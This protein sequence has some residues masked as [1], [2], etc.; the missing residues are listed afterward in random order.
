M[1]QK[2]YA[3]LK[4]EW[5][6]RLQGRGLF[7]ALCGCLIESRKDLS[8][9]HIICRSKGGPTE[10]WN[11]QPTHKWCN[12]AR[13]DMPMQKWKRQGYSTLKRLVDAWDRNGTKYNHVKV[14]KCLENLR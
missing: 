11:L 1:H 7:C 3:N 2:S 12:S 6:V 8:A 4:R 5:L 13:G 9:D 10:A 14:H